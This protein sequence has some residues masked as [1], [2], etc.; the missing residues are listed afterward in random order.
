MYLV[1][2]CGMCTFGALKTVSGANATTFASAIM[3]IQLC[4]G[5]CHTIILDKDKKFYGVCRKALDLLKINCHVLLGD[6]H[7]P[8]LVECLCRYF[9]KGL[10]IM[11][12]KRDTVCVALECLLLLLYTWN[13]CPILGTDIS[14]SLIAVGCKFAFP[15]DFSSGKHWQLTLSPATVES[16]S[17][18]LAMH[19][20]LST[21]HKIA[22]LL[23][24]ETCDWHRALVNSCRP[25]P[26]VYSP[27]DI[28]FCSPRH[29]FGC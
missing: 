28:F 7:N 19:L 25:D 20:S 8:M 4:Y 2:C 26:R 9:N 21:C 11:C 10:T 14:R 13:S 1:T 18:A 15:I 23:V 17:K 12:N 16:Y 6:N 5:F 22:D 3:K 24:S 27:G 29:P